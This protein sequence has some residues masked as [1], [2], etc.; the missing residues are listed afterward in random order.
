VLTV[1]QKKE[2]MKKPRHIQYVIAL[3][4]PMAAIADDRATIIGGITDG[5]PPPPAPVKELPE[6]EVRETVI[7]ELPD[8]TVTINRVAD[9]KLPNPRPKLP[10]R[11]EL[12][13]DEIEAFRASPEVQAWLEQRAKTTHM[14][15]SATVIDRRATLLRW[16]HDGAEYQAW[17]N[18]DWMILTG[19]SDFEKGDRHYT[20]LLMAGRLDSAS[21]ASDSAYRIP[22]NLPE[23]PGTFIITKG[24]PANH[25]AISGIVALHEI[26]LNDY[27][28]LAAAYEL[29][30]RRRIERE[31]ELRANPPVPEDVVLHYW[32]VQPE[33]PRRGYDRKEEPQP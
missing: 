14:F 7:R 21:V 23:N 24:D 32:K 27:A 19:F 6:V 9:P 11:N 1:V 8:R 4:L 26:Y 5:T 17:S 30:E 28:R 12:N 20:A 31:A 33:R 16:W 3:L 18:A 29:R 10:E 13:S 15:I 2:N 22:E 25:G